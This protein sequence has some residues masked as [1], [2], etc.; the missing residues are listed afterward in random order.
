[1][2][3]K[4][5]GFTLVELM[6]TMLIFSIIIATMFGVLSVGRQSW[7]TGS[8]QVDLQQET[9]KAMGRMVK[10]LRK[11]GSDHVTID[12]GGA[13]ITFQVPVDWDSDGDVVDNNGDVEWGAEANLD[14]SLQYYLNS[15]NRGLLRRVLDGYPNGNQVGVDTT[16]ANN[17]HS[18]SPPPNALMFIG[19]PA[20][21]PAVINI[22]VTAQKDTARGRSMQS[23]LYSQVTL[24]N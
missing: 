14:G 23:T 13:R 3:M 5:R 4:N 21:N 11:T 17:I 18:D 1:M 2:I 9:R 16:L 8:T 6:V 22:E 19:S 7:Y 10:E 15:S 20:L 12:N 24:R